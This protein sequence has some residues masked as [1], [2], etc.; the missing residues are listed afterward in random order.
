MVYR[1][2][3]RSER[4]D[5]TAGDEVRTLGLALSTTSSNFKRSRAGINYDPVS[6][7]CARTEIKAAEASKQRMFVA[8]INTNSMTD[9][10]VGVS[11]TQRK[12]AILRIRRRS[13]RENRA[14]TPRY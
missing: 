10:I 6:P 9:G 11:F 3:S 2:A 12:G 1:R 14:I 5:R 4:G 13:S 7:L 8:K